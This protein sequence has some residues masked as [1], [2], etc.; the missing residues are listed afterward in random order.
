[1]SIAFFYL[2]LH[3]DAVAITASAVLFIC[4]FFLLLFFFLCFASV[5]QSHVN[6]HCHRLTANK[7]TNSQNA[8]SASLEFH[9]S[10]LRI[11]YVVNLHD[12]NSCKSIFLMFSMLNLILSLQCFVLA[13]R[14]DFG[15]PF[16]VDH[17]RFD[18]MHRMRKTRYEIKKKNIFQTFKFGANY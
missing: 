9:L 2:I 1:M 15:M 3:C 13:N 6:Y 8:R 16:L 4:L 11:H 7:D 12:E 17:W 10:T 18:I 14:D 5:T